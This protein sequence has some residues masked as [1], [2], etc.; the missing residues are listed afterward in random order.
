[1]ILVI[2]GTSDGREIAQQLKNS[3]CIVLISTAT[4]YGYNIAHNSGLDVIKGKL[5]CKGLVAL[6]DNYLIRLV[7]DAS[8]PYAE[9]ITKNTLDACR[10]KDITYIR[11]CR[12]LGESIDNPLVVEADSYQ[13]AAEKAVELGDSIFLTAG[14]KNS[15]LFFKRLQAKNKRLIIRVTPDPAVIGELLNM[16]VSPADL[17]AMQGPF[18]EGINI[19]MLKHFKA[20]VMITKES[21]K[22]GGY[23]EK[24]SAAIKLGIP[25]VVIKRPPEPPG[26]ICSIMQTVEKALL[27]SNIDILKT[28]E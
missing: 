9:E 22:E 2:G 28:E 4:D 27:L 5:D 25:V 15:G 16:G 18:S 8:H 7:V 3:G 21:G 14:S 19:E 6:M 23:Q 10:K 20:D 17:I 1:V 13:Q 24:I 12:P 11:Y 26:A